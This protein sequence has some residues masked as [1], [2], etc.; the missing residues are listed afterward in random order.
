MEYRPFPEEREDEFRAFMRY[1]FS[2]EQGPYDP[3]SEDDDREHL[4]DYRGLFD[5]DDT[6]AVCGHHEFSLR[7]RG[8]DRTAAGLSAVASPPEHRRQGNV[9]RLLRESLSEYREDGVQFSV[10]WPFEYGFYR[11]YGWATV[12]RYRHVEIPPEQLRFV[13]GAIARATGADRRT[14]AS[15]ASGTSGVGGTRR[16]S[17]PTG[18]FRRLDADDHA[19]A[20]SVLSAMADRYDFTMARTEPW[21]RERS[22]RG[23]KTDP[24][25]YGWER[26][27]EL[28][29]FWSYTFE[30]GPDDERVMTVRDVA[31]VDEEAWLHA[32]RFCRDHDSQ[33]GTV[34]IRAP[35]DANL[36][37]RVADPREVTVESRTGPMFRLVDV[38]GA[39]ESIAPDPRLDGSVTLA[40]DDP[41][42]AW[43]DRTFLIAVEDGRVSV[44]TLGASTTGGEGDD[45]PDADLRVGIGTL[46]Q[47]YAGYHSVGEATEFGD[48][49]RRGT[50]DDER[51]DDASGD[52]DEVT[53]DDDEV[54][55]GATRSALDD[56]HALLPPRRT[57]LREGF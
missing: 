28:R 33:V 38:P 34:R 57:F 37:D 3:E 50:A 16:A 9:E 5:G 56:L 47:L 10:L 53:A 27:G 4:A 6:V 21:W 22:L 15:G 36:Q 26:D 19:A 42:A 17:G 18:R 43:N 51:D 8:A 44:E 55:A 46:S 49:T 24:F 52:D 23:W 30:D 35:P 11:K 14:G 12:S 40:V 48:L 41:L 54:T 32:L 7:I 1:A 29:A 2:P 39:F 13:D 31:A 45:A 25:V 20:R